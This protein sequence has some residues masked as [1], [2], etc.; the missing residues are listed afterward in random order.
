[1]SNIRATKSGF[2]AEAHAKI[3]SKYNEDH[4][5][6]VMEWINA[7]TGEPSNTSG[8]PENV[9]QHLRDGTLLCKLANVMQPGT[10]KRVQQS[11]MAFKCME[12]INSFLDA[13]RAFGVPS[14]E[15]FQTVD[16]WEKQNLNAVIIC[17]QAL[18]RKASKYGQCSIGPKEADKNERDFTEE[19]LRAG[20]T[21]IGLQAGSNKGANQSGLNFGNT[22][23]M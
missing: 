9:Y 12:N 13:A 20:D 15:L 2:A 21:I 4:A 16:L 23:H 10:I 6:E 1:M 19:Q 5:R 7:L 11:Q 14:Q 8:D 17:L 3:M 18:G 22:R